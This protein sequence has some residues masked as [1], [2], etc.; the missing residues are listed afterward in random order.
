MDTRAMSYDQLQ[1]YVNQLIVENE[2]LKHKYLECYKAATETKEI[3]EKCLVEVDIL[4]EMLHEHQ[5]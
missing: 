3:L 5:R 2:T 1:I 4:K